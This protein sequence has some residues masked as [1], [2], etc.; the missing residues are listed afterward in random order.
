MNK[1]DGEEAEPRSGGDEAAREEG[2]VRVS[3]R[4]RVRLDDAGEG[5]R[6]EAEA[7]DAPSLKP[8]YVEELEARTRAAEQKALDVQARF[9]QVR[10]QLQRETDETRQR[11]NRAAE[12][13]LTR[14]KAG[15]VA[16]LLPV[17]DNLRRAIDAAQEGGGGESLLDGLRG[18]LSG[19]E[20]AL[21]NAGVEPVAAVGEQFDPELHE[22]VDTVEVEP[23]R[24]G[25]ITAEYSRGYRLGD[26][27]VRPARVQVGRS[28]GAQAAAE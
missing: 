27:L 28:R 23:G 12:E 15:F 4:R 16:S 3:D 1:R 13:R 25:E 8:K 20:G 7:G 19:F 18:T 9:E 2:S 11:L 26:Q 22:A 6:V 5:V 14:E 24:D 21:S 17:V 10:A